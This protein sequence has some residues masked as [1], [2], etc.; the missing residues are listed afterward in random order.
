MPNFIKAKSYPIG[1]INEQEQVK[2]NS[3]FKEELVADVFFNFHPQHTLTR[4]ADYLRVS[5]MKFDLPISYHSLPKRPP[6]Q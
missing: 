6:K 1:K 5:T 4:I 2:E 3:E